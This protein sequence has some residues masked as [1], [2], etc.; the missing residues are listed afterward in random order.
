MYLEKKREKIVF[1]AEIQSHS[2]DLQMVLEI[3]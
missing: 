3:Q 1:S 2:I